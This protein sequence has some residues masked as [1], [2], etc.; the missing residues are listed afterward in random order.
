MIIRSWGSFGRPRRL[1]I[2]LKARCLCHGLRDFPQSVQM[3]FFYVTFIMSLELILGF[4]FP[5]SNRLAALNLS[6]LI[7]KILLNK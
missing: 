2:G 7:V 6:Y 1:N 4:I 3:I 5:T